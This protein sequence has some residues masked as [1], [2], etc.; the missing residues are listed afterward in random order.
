MSDREMRNKN[1]NGEISCYECG[2]VIRGNKDY[3][4]LE[5]YDSPFDEKSKTIHL[6]MEN[7]IRE[8]YGISCA[9]ALYDEQWADFRY[10]DC[11]ICHRTIISRCPSN[12]WHS[13]VREYED[14][15][16]CLSC[17]EKIQFEDGASQESFED[18]RIEGM[19][20]NTGDFAEQGFECVSGF[21][22][23]FI[24]TSEDTMNYCGTALRLIEEGYIIVNEYNRMAIGGLEGYVTMWRKRKEA[25]NR[26]RRYA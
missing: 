8:D 17:F 20:F 18:G 13:Y 24:R 11:F 5:V 19:F 7:G 23:Y 15:E 26:E 1:G 2:E 16:I 3:T 6:H 4:T 10:F 14:M 22:G 25:E 12:G 21:H 9:Q